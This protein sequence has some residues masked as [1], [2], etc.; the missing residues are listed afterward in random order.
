MTG[1]GLR[2]VL[3]AL[4]SSQCRPCASWKSPRRLHNHQVY[5]LREGIYTAKTLKSCCLKASRQAGISC[6]KGRAG[7]VSR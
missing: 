6:R 2:R 7:V 5:N 1:A 3:T 4:L